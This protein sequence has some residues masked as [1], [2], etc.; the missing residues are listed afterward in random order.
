LDAARDESL[1]TGSHCT[2]LACGNFACAC[3]HCVASVGEV[4]VSLRKTIPAPPFD[5]FT[6]D[7]NACWKSAHSLVWPRRRTSFERSGS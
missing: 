4:M 5:F 2:S 3:A 1:F 7:E 6:A